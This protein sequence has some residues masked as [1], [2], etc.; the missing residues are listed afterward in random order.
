MLNKV[1]RDR[2]TKAQRYLLA[3]AE[4]QSRIS[5]LKVGLTGNIGS[6]KSTVAK[7]FSELGAPTFD[8]DK[9]GHE[10]LESDA[11]IQS[12]IVETFGKEIILDG[13]ISRH[14]LAKIV[15]SNAAKKAKLESILHPAIMKVLNERVSKNVSNGYAIMEAA[16][17]YEAKL[18]DSFDYMILVKVDKDIAV[19]RAAKNL[20]IR[21]QDVLKRL[22]MQIP[23]STK[24]K[25]ADFVIANNG[26]LEEL[27]QRV[28]LLHNIIFS[29]SKKPA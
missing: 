29:L 19:E 11:H 2:V 18:A 14:Q 9:I 22:K 17:I 13:M 20:G 23:Q 4:E 16:L 21:K 28:N 8:A 27:R 5:P 25:L 3:V 7:M 10:I 6:G 1:Q 26:S 15:F 12:R 24:E